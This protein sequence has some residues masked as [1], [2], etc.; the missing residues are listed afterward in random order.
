MPKLNVQQNNQNVIQAFK[1]ALAIGNLKGIIASDGSHNFSTAGSNRNL[2]DNPWFTVRQRGNGPFSGA[3]YTVDRWKIAGGNVVVTPR[4]PYGVNLNWT[5]ACAYDEYFD[6]DP[7]IL[8][9]K[10]VTLSAM[11][12][13]VVYSQSAVYSTSGTYVITITVGNV[14]FRLGY[15]TSTGR[16]FIRIGERVSNVATNVN[17]DAVKL[18][19]GSVST[20]ANDAPPKESQVT[21]DCKWY[22]QRIQQEDGYTAPVGFGIVA[23]STTILR[24]LIPLSSPLRKAGTLTA[25][26]TNI[27]QMR[28]QGNGSNLTPTAITGRGVLN[29]HAVVDITVNGTLASNQFYTLVFAN[30]S[31]TIDLSKDL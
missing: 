18:E 15:L 5:T 17:V 11:V 29:G 7:Q 9:G 6:I 12:D 13:G 21:D 1:N 30:S 31:A 8:V 3:G 28:V 20:L 27:G 19:L 23:A 2:L 10:T 16:V 4:S 14:L 24:T 26:A 22:F 25:T